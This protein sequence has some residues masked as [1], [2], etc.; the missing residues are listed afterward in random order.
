MHPVHAGLTAIL[1]VAFGLTAP[2][3][4]RTTVSSA[5]V[6]GRPDAA[7][8][9][10]AVLG[11]V[12]CA[13]AT[14][15]FAAG[16]FIPGA[17]GNQYRPLIERF[18]GTRWS[19]AP[20]A[21]PARPVQ[22]FGVSCASATDCVAVGTEY[23]HL[24]GATFAE[25]WNGTQWT[26]TPVP[27]PPNAKDSELNGVSCTGDGSCMAVGVENFN[28]DRTPAA[29][30]ERWDGTR[31][32]VVPVPGPASSVSILTGVSCAAASDCTADGG[33]APLP[34]GYPESTLTEHWNGTG[35]RIVPS[36][37][38]A[39]ARLS[40][41]FA[42]SCPPGGGCLATGDFFTVSQGNYNSH[43]LA[44]RWNGAQWSLVLAPAPQATSQNQLNG[45]SC[46]MAGACMAVGYDL[47]AGGLMIPL[48]ESW[49]GHRF[50]VLTAPSPPGSA[51]GLV[52]VSCP[53]SRV[54]VAAGFHGNS[55]GDIVTLTEVWQ[56]GT[57]RI[58]PSPSP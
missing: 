51:A 37:D 49:D 9:V 2:A 57:W 15:C 31:W 21:V 35:W 22:L 3:A 55:Q 39:H 16:S 10:Y 14:E 50:S 24:L 25:H 53:G 17:L 48:A 41:L 1:A 19:V 33:Y 56:H 26:V 7:G 28:T 4:G 45:V 29:I 13:R 18:N 47:S 46:A 58:V 43:N 44:E 34:G 40:A 23:S 27:V 54:C 38:P 42:V 30:A 11:S 52:G 8:T 36:P 5:A 6:P 20:A 32:T 12:S